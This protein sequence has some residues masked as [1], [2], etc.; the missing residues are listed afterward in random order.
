MSSDAYIFEVT[1]KT[2]PS[3]VL[4]NSHKTPVIVEFMGVWSEPCIVIEQIFT[5]LAKEF[6]G[7]FIFAKIDVNEQQELV[8]QY[9]IE[10]IPT[11]IVIKEGKA[12]RFDMGQITEDEARDIL[13][14]QSIGHESDDLREQAREKH[15]AGDTQSAIMLLT[16]AIQKHPGNTRVAMDMVQIFLDIGELESASGLLQKLPEVDRKSEMGQTLNRQIT[17]LSL[18]VKTEGIEPLKAK[19]LDNP[20]D[21]Q[22][23]FDL[24]ICLISIYEYAD[25]MEHLLKIVELAP[26][27]QDGAAKEMV[28]MVV[29]ILKPES[30]DAANEYQR[31]LSNI[32]AQ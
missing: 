23:R 12:Q 14:E 6:A 7:Q 10:N 19:L 18:A 27:F 15:L 13:R 20:D 30:P 2:F 29:R 31:K 8:K 22:S 11:I 16:Q 25:A 9:Q 5:R 4:E 28:S 21:H 24:A 1:E 32:L 3:I 26:D 17:F